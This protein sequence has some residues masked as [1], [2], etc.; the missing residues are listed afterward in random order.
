VNMEMGGVRKKE[1]LECLVIEETLKNDR[2]LF[3]ISENAG[4]DAKERFNLKRQTDQYL[5]WYQELP[6]KQQ[7]RRSKEFSDS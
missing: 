7:N 2:L 4:K 5:K 6:R 3:R 1:L